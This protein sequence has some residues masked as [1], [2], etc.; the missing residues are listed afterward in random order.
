M[1]P[2]RLTM[3]A[4]GSY[5]EAETIDFSR[6]GQ[7]VF[8]IT[9]DTGAGKT[10]IF[11]GITFALYGET[12]GGKREAEMMRSQYASESAST[13]VEFTFRCR[14]EEYRI[15]RHPRQRRVSRRRN[16]DGRLTMVEEAPKVELTLPDGTIFPGRGKEINEKIIQIIGLDK[17]QFTQ[18]AMIAQGD[19]LKLLHAPSKERKEIFSKIF[20]T[21]LYARIEEELRLRAKELAFALE[22]NKQRIIRELE[23]IRCIPDSRLSGE[24]EELGHFSERRQ[25][26]QLALAREIAKEALEREQALEQEIREGKK[27][28]EELSLAVSKG[29]EQNRWFALFN[30]ALH[31]NE[32]LK[33]REKAMEQRKEEA[34]A[35]EK[36]ALAQPKEELVLAG[37]REVEQQGKEIAA[38]E[39]WLGKSRKLLEERKR[40]LDKAQEEYQEKGPRLIAQ[41]ERIFASMDSYDQLE[42]SR[43]EVLALEKEEEKIAKIQQLGRE[44]FT[45]QAA[46]LE[47]LGTLIEENEQAARALLVLE[48]ET[49]ERRERKRELNTLAASL[50]ELEGRKETMERLEKES[51]VLKGAS[52]ELE[53][54]YEKLYQQ[55]LAGQAGWLASSLKPGEPCPV[56]GSPHHP[57]P[58]YSSGILVERK[59]LDSEKARAQKAALAL[60]EG[61]E[62]FRM[63]R[64]EYESQRRLVD[65]EGRRLL[66]QGK[67]GGAF[68]EEWTIQR[69]KE[70]GK[71]AWLACQEE[72]LAKERAREAALG[73]E[74]AGKSQ[75]AEKERLEKSQRELS[76]GQEQL[77][78]RQKE[79]EVRKATCASRIQVLEKTLLY[80]G[81]EQARQACRQAEEE[82]RGLEKMLEQAQSGYQG[83]ESQM[84]AKQGSLEEKRQSRTRM[85]EQ[86]ARREAEFWAALGSQGFGGEEDYRK[87]KRSDEE[88]KK[89]EKEYQEYRDQRTRSEERLKHCQDQIRGKDPVVL[90][91]L[92]EELEKVKKEQEAREKENR[93]IY[94]IRTRDEALAERSGKLW[95]A[96]TEMLSRYQVLKRLDDTANGKV[97]QRHLNFQTYIQRSYFSLVIREA[98]KRLL[99]MSSGQ[100][101]LQCREMKDLGSQGEVG[102]DLDVYS[103]INHQTRDVKTLSGGESFLAALAM[104]LGMS[105]IIQNSAGSIRIDTMFIDEG[106]GSLSEETRMQAIQIL[107]QL[108]GGKRLVGIISHVT[109]LKDQIETKLLVVKGEKGSRTEWREG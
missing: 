3:C 69:M 38:L 27:R 37:R 33:A 61:E 64:Q 34:R 67:P 10:T 70:A 14:G 73:A 91:G 49:A 59:R 4:F 5:A 48:R 92:L 29:E 51:Q 86:L 18:T 95:E 6:A 81:K 53:A 52:Q 32:G 75:R 16:K 17:N 35:A 56:C 28:Q 93:L 54:R 71:A 100:F 87:A 78:G 99:T 46:R 25:E 42:D 43:R 58:A 19:F 9:G 106:F 76:E 7:G 88:R 104:A 12:S 105:D 47:T 39:E 96:R 83:L 62:N 26:Q 94:G 2:V 55:F 98:N 40:E 8:L 22:E 102:L 20:N 72:L 50:K 74:E 85:E 24:W 65:H 21:R 23:D 97:S 15:L 101:L 57:S 13:Y 107:N 109:E 90:E 89:A 60:A 1:K 41:I 77:A 82:K 68:P 45:R 84:Q 66:D 30:Q 44:Q 31:E 108:S 63:A 103:L 36:A 79:L 11:D 80:P